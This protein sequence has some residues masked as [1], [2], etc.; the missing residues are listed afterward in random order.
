MGTLSWVIVGLLIGIVS[1]FL[2]VQ[3]HRRRD[4]ARATV[5]S[6]LV[7]RKEAVR[8]SNPFAAVSVRPCDDPCNAVLQM[9]HVRYLAVRAPRLPVAGCDKQQCDCR[10]QRHADRRSPGDRRDNFARFGGLMPNSSKN[11]RKD[12]NDRRRPKD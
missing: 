6:G 10:Y 3:F 1:P 9:N 2:V 11:R 4:L 5:V 8:P 12:G 7:A